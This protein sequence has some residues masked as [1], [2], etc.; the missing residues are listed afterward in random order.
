MKEK[1][2]TVAIANCCINLP[3]Y[4]KVNYEMAMIFDCTEYKKS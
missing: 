1:I 3:V 4:A 2:I